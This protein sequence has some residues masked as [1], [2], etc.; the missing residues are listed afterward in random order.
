MNIKS[1]SESVV[2]WNRRIY[3]ASSIPVRR[4][5]RQ[6]KEHTSNGKDQLEKDV[7]VGDLHALNK[8]Q[9][10]QIDDDET[11]CSIGKLLQ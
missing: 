5:R 8:L 10:M 11:C 6:R 3:I 1:L 7:E 2:H 4:K 9:E